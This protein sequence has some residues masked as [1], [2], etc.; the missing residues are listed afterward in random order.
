MPAKKNL[1]TKNQGSTLEIKEMD[2]VLEKY[3]NFFPE[4]I[5][6]KK[7]WNFVKK[8][9]FVKNSFFFRRGKENKK[10]FRDVKSLCVKKGKVKSS[11]VDFKKKEKIYKNNFWKY[12]Y[13]ADKVMKK[14]IFK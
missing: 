3:E 1:E 11:R 9:V 14:F 5:S 6:K 7:N 4:E 13:M 12:K 8:K 10:V 2:K